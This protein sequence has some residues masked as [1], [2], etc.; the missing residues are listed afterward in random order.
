MKR[1][2]AARLAVGI[3][4]TAFV[5]LT[6][7]A[8][9]D[10]KSGSGA[11]GPTTTTLH[12]AESVAA[13]PSVSAKMI[14]ED[15]VADDIYNSATGVKTIAPFKP[16]WVDHLYSCDYVYP[17]GA[18][19]RLAVKELASDAET[20]AYYNSLATKLGKIK[21]EPRIAQKGLAEAAFSTKDGSV[22]ARKDYKVVL[23]DVSELPENFGAP[24]AS[25]SDVAVDV[26][27]TIMNCWTGL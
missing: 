20:T 23:I 24:A 25:R 14:C 15:E 17:H 27:V 2:L 1:D 18:V 21:N 9:D 22:V 11:K 4:L 8:C 12:I 26:G 6:L 16:T 19:M 7:T 10:S 5:A 3:L 13:T